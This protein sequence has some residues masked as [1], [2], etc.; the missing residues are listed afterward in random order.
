DRR[1]SLISGNDIFGNNLYSSDGTVGSYDTHPD[2]KMIKNIGVKGQKKG[3]RDSW[4]LSGL[5]DDVEKDGNVN[6]AQLNGLLI[7]TLKEL[8]EKVEKLEKKVK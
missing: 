5:P 4:D 1:W 7:G 6:I 8:I 2:I 3:K